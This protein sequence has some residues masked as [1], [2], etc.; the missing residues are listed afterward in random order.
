METASRKSIDCRKQSSMMNCSVKMSADN[1][2]ELLEAA[3][4]HAISIH[5]EIDTPE[6]RNMLM[7]SM[8]NET[9]DVS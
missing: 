3:V 8:E 4:G 1:A 2:Q 6:L 5:G 7:Q 9:M